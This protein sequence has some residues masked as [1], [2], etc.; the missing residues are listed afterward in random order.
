MMRSQYLA[1]KR[2]VTISTRD[3]AAEEELALSFGGER[4]DRSEE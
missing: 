4:T 2:A 1:D 3:G